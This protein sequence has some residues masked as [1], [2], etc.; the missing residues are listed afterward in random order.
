MKKEID[1]LDI[2]FENAEVSDAEVL[3]DANAV[4]R[5]PL[6]V[7]FGED[8]YKIYHC[9]KPLSPAR[10]IQF[11]KDITDSFKDLGELSTDIFEPKKKLGLELIEDAE[12]YDGEWKS[13]AL[14]GSA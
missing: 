14:P 11:E 10:Y 6:S 13:D 2:D 9:L 5:I 3:Y 1:E 4:Q 7:P 8:V 12:G